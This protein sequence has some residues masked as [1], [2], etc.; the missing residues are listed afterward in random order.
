MRSKRFDDWPCPIARTVDLLGD[1]WIPLIL[2]ECTYDVATFGDFQARLGIAP[3]TLSARLERMVELGLLE[4]Q[5][6]E[7]R[8]PRFA[9]RL[10]AMGHDA[11]LIL[12]AMLR[13]GDDWLFERGQAPIVLR[14]RES[15]RRVRPRVVDERSGEPIDPRAVRPDAGPGFPGDAK[16]RREWF[17]PAPVDTDT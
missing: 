9:Y 17:H 16:L 11:T 1:P 15:G 13:F 6:Y 10:S 3:G 5:A 2:R 4:K 14:D 12:A 7:E 8:P